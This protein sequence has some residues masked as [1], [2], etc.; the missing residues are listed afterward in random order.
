MGVIIQR[1]IPS[2][3]EIDIYPAI[4]PNWGDA[5]PIKPSQAQ[6]IIFEGINPD[7][8]LY[9]APYL[10]TGYESKNDL[11]EEGTTYLNTGKPLYEAGLD[12]K[13]GL[14]SNIILDLTV[15]TDFAQVEND[16]EK[17]NLTRMAEYFPEKRMFFLERSSIFDF[18]SN[19]NNNL[20]YSRR[21]GL[22]EDGDPI[23]I[24][25]GARLTGKI[26]EWDFGVLNMQTAPLMKKNG[27]GI[28]KEII[29]SENF[30]VIRL[31]RKLLNDNS[32]IG[33]IITSR[34]DMMVHLILDMALMV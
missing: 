33:S 32:Y 29:P 21:I 17:I 6:E 13:Y 18:N 27:S 28:A 22:S 31:R 12:V 19:G 4:L 26:K 23:R 7:K 30:G 11:N 1:W 15:N 5:S 25:G 3:N 2:K 9:L 8:P 10:L 34:L 14:S 20:F 24:Y 16:D